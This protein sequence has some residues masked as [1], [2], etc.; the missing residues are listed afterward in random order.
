M[1]KLFALALTA[2]LLVGVLCG[3]ALA[4]GGSELVQ[5]LMST[6]GVTVTPAVQGVDAADLDE[7]V[8]NGQELIPE[9]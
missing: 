7:A 8:E 9:D 6:P 5:V 3:S 1:K 2:A 4:D